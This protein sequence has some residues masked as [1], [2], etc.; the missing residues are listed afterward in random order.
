MHADVIN[1][2]NLAD[3]ATFHTGATVV[4]SESVTG[5]TPPTINS[6]TNGAAI[7]PNAFVFDQIP[8]VQF[9]WEVWSVQMN[10]PCTNSPEE[11][12]VMPSPLIPF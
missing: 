12:P 6:Y 9:P 5:R 7:S 2:N 10:R 11:L 8:G 3:V 4:N 1:T